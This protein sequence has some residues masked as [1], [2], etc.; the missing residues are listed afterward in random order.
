M[1]APEPGL[2]ESWVQDLLARAM[3][4]VA[5]GPYV[6]VARD[7]EDGSL[8]LTGPFASVVDAFVAVEDEARR[9]SSYPE[10]VRLE[11]SVAP[12]AQP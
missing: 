2:I 7:P 4:D 11:L 5:D 3:T 10:R 9:Q 12:L 6:M 1:D 8:Y